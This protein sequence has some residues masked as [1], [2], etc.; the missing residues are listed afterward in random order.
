MC[1]S[2]NPI[3]LSSAKRDHLCLRVMCLSEKNLLVWGKIIPIKLL[4]SQHPH[5]VNDHLGFV[6]ETLLYPNHTEHQRQCQ[7]CQHCIGIHCDTWEWVWHQFSSVTIHKHWPLPLPLMPPLPLTL[8]VV[9]P[10]VLV[11]EW[12]KSPQT[13]KLVSTSDRLC[14]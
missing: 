8:G 1:F 5:H 10:L 6:S 13:Q 4:W 9:R 14:D 11:K 2:R 12:A 3:T 7:Q